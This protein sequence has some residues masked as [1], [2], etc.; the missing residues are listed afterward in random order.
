MA[1]VCGQNRY[2]DV[3]DVGRG[4]RDTAGGEDLQGGLGFL[5]LVDHTS[6]KFRFVARGIFGIRNREM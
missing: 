1:S 3:G 2:L 5:E 4:Q 6:M